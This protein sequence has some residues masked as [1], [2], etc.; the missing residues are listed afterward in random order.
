LLDEPELL[1]RDAAAKAVGLDAKRPAAL[2]QLGAGYNR[3]IVSLIGDLVG[4][5]QKVRGLQ[6]CIAEW[7]NG[8]E[9]LSLWSGIKLLRGFPLSQY[10]RA[11]DFSIAA[12]GYNTFHDAI[13]LGLPT[14]FIPNR[15]PAMDNQAA[16]AE[17]AQSRQAAFELDEEDLSD[18]PDLIMLMMDEKARAFIVEK[19]S[20]LRLENGAAAAAN[21]IE[22]LAGAVS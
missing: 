5:L 3:D 11:F 15:H 16:R 9:G 12:A 21:A 17:Y 14:I 20:S 6:I 7:V 18:L 22:S 1:S 13:A 10:Y 8:A 2:I 4:E 19:R